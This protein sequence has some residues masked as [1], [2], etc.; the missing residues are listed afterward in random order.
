MICTF[1]SHCILMIKISQFLLS[2]WCRGC[3]RLHSN[4]KLVSLFFSVAEKTFF[5]LLF[6]D[7]F[8]ADIAVFIF[9]WHAKSKFSLRWEIFQSKTA[10]KQ[11]FCPRGK[12]SLS[13]ADCMCMFHYNG[14][15]VWVI[16]GDVTKSLG[17]I[18]ISFPRWVLL[19]ID[20]N[21]SECKEISR[22]M[23]EKFQFI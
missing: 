6:W 1:V 16:Y 22:I 23:S 21:T 9:K 11:N 13:D 12:H 7:F 19:F 18:R 20:N 10:E 14:K 3:S 4:Q 2:N 17:P 15:L 5:P 8:S